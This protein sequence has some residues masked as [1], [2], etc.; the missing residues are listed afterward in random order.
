MKLKNFLLF[1][2]FLITIN[3]VYALGDPCDSNTCEFGNVE[4]IAKCFVKNNNIDEGLVLKKN[5][6]CAKAFRSNFCRA[7]PKQDQCIKIGQ[8]I[9][10]QNKPK[11]TTNT[12][13]KPKAD[14]Y[15][16]FLKDDKVNNK[17][18]CDK[19]K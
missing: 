11:T 14:P 13:T 18:L 12:Y 10:N 8:I 15:Q 1:T 9:D 7:N 3:S 4:I 19:Y 17:N 2:G 6:N 16:Q 5:K